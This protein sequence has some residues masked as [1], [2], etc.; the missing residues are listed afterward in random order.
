MSRFQTG[1]YAGVNSRSAISFHFAYQSWSHHIGDS[2]PRYHGTHSVFGCSEDATG[3]G[4]W[5]DVEL[6]WELRWSAV[7]N[8]KMVRQWRNNGRCRV[9]PLSKVRVQSTLAPWHHHFSSTSIEINDSPWLAGTIHK[10]VAAAWTR[11][12]QSRRKTHSRSTQN[13]PRAH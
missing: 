13:W 7:G 4:A 10:I 12:H 11:T 8:D 5:W 1:S 6:S 3:Y 9:G 2:H